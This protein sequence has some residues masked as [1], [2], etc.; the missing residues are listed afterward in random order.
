MCVL[1]APGV[2]RADFLSDEGDLF[3]RR[4]S[5]NDWWRDFIVLG[6]QSIF[7]SA[8][9]YRFGWCYGRQTEH[10]RA[11]ELVHCRLHGRTRQRAPPPRSTFARSVAAGLAI[12]MVV[13]CPGVRGGRWAGDAGQNRQGDES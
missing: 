2:T 3:A 4:H 10:R 9:D 8:A 1:G 6:C 5:L 11:H 7:I 13:E 12:H